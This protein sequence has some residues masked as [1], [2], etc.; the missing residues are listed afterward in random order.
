MYHHQFVGWNSRLDAIQAAVLRIKLP[1]LDD[2]SR[3][4]GAN[5]ER[6]DRWFEET[7]LVAAGRVRL[8]RRA[9]DSSHIF[10][11]YTLRV[12]RRDELR[13][14][15]NAEGIGHSVYYPV[16]LHLQECFGDLGYRKGEFPVAERACEEVIALPIYPELTSEHQRRVVDALVGFYRSAAG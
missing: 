9:P 5:A 13:A 1:H 4:R 11:Q 14:H 7:G 10:N 8:P 15:L 16:P 3:G 12:E 2:W 6:Y